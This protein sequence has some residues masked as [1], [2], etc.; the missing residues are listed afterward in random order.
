MA[1]LATAQDRS[2]RG[3]APRAEIRDEA[4]MFGDSAVAKAREQLEKIA[5][6]SAVPVLIETIETV[7]SGESIRSAAVERARASE[8]RGIFV[9]A[10]RRDRHIDVLVSKDFSARITDPQRLEI[11]QAFIDGFRQGDYDRGLLDGIARIAKT[12]GEEKEKEA[13]VASARS[14]PVRGEREGADSS[15]LVVRDQVR[16]SLAGA[17]RILAG[18]RAKAAEM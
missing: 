7:P 14:S 1:G 4:G 17:E 13:P 12:V 18:A 16:L 15:P 2:S 5:S 8:G 3:H 6:R 11:R 10:S 9:L